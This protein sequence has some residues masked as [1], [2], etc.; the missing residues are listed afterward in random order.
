M[1]VPAAAV[2]SLASSDGCCLSHD[3]GER[4]HGHDGSVHRW[5]LG[6]A[7]HSRQD[8]SG[9]HSTAAGPCALPTRVV[10]ATPAMNSPAAH[11]PL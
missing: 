1:S 9:T 3:R 2:G 7:D 5:R 8:G 6:C 11:W 4:G 10:K